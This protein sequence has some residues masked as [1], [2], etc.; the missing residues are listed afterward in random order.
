MINTNSEEVKEQIEKMVSGE[1]WKDKANGL[2]D[3]SLPYAGLATEGI[4]QISNIFDMKNVDVSEELPSQNYAYGQMPDSFVWQENPY[5]GSIGKDVL[6]NSFGGFV[7][8]AKTG[9]IWAALGGGVGGVLTGLIGGSY[10]ERNENDYNI[11]QKKRWGEYNQATENY[12]MYQADRERD[13][14]RT[15]YMSRLKQSIPTYGTSI[16]SMV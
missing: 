9:N 3:K 2:L 13:R 8:G 4:S 14:S 11:E 6:K 12:D 7:E 16:Y 15:G 1:S 10:R 5:E